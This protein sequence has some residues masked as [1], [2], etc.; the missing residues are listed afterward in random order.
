[1]ALVEKSHG[2]SESIFPVS[3]AIG[4]KGWLVKML[5]FLTVCC[6]ALAAADFA[7]THG[8][9]IV[10]LWSAAAVLAWMFLRGA[11]QASMRSAQERFRK[12]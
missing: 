8:Y 6:L 1:M 3:P 5:G 10:D 12:E 4:A 7:F 2:K 11:S 9:W